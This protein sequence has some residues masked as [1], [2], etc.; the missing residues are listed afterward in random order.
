MVFNNEDKDEKII[1]VNCDCGCEE[2]IH[3]K[4][5]DQETNV[6]YL[7]IHE[8][9]FSSKQNGIFK[10]IRNRIKGAWRILRGKEYLLCDILLNK[11]Q[12]NEFIEKLQN[13]QK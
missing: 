10:T 4:V 6:Y 1:V 3:I 5:F 2:E 8:A 7:T 13:I 9:K 12:L 11:K